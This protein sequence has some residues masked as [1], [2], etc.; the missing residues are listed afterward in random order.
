MTGSGGSQSPVNLQ[1]NGE[2]NVKA[3][4]VF[5]DGRQYYGF[6]WP[7]QLD[8]GKYNNPQVVDL[9]TSL[10]RKNNLAQTTD[11]GLSPN[12]QY[13]GTAPTSI[14]DFENGK[15]GF[16]ETYLATTPPANNKIITTIVKIVDYLGINTAF[17][18]VTAR[19]WWDRLTG[20]VTPT[21]INP[22]PEII[23]DPLPD[24]AVIIDKEAN[25]PIWAIAPD[26]GSS[27]IP[28][29]NL[30][31]NGFSPTI[32]YANIAP[33]VVDGQLS[34]N[35][36]VARGLADAV[37]EGL[38]CGFNTQ[39]ILCNTLQLYLGDALA[40][41]PDYLKTDLE[42]LTTFNAIANTFLAV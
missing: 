13:S 25:N 32:Y 20:N 36:K 3:P 24:I 17:P 1:A 41:I 6:D 21:E 37:I 11:L 16:G 2:S 31:Q 15:M 14:T 23:L 4:I 18:G 38:K 39:S 42:V 7:E 34:T 29:Q 28:A 27:I 22:L 19:N 35:P 5:A 9:T 26:A 12:D 10:I 40:L 8:S 33:R 30:V